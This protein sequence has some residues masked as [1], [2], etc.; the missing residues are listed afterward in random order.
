[1][2]KRVLHLL[3]QRPGLTGSGITILSFIKHAQSRG[4]DQ[5]VSIGIPAGDD[6]AKRISGVGIEVVPLYFGHAPL[7]FPIPGMSD[8]MPYESTRFSSMDEATLNRY[9]EGWR[10]HLNTLKERGPYDV[11][12]THHIW[13]MSSLVRDVFPDTPIVNHCHGTGL[14]QMELCPELAPRVREACRRHEAFAVLHE[15]HKREVSTKLGVEPNLVHV[16][17]AGYRE[18][19]FYNAPR[20]G[21]EQ[22]ICYAGKFSNAK[23]VPE[24]L[25]AFRGLS[26]QHPNC[27]LHLAGSGSGP[28]SEAIEKTID[29]MGARVI[30][31]GR[32]SQEDLAALMRTAHTFVLPSYY[33]GLPLVLVEALASGA[34]LVSNAL[35]G[36]VDSLAPILGD[37]LKLVKMPPLVGPD[38]PAPDSLPSYISRLETAL[39]ESQTSSSN[40]VAEESGPNTALTPFQWGAVFQRVEAIWTGL[41]KRAH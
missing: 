36:V 41:S 14:R 33:E 7:E 24:L 20:L 37:Q 34:K 22:R 23:G 5:T 11:I 16:V 9:C 31:H 30:H 15:E 29:S 28:E 8:V 18:D 25:E 12:H 3:S 10:A 6:S 2:A 32:L 40:A 35:P 39:Y 4:W 19:L 13:L 26:A 1:M 17:G 21:D 27:S 38:T